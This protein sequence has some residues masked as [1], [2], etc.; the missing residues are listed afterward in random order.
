MSAPDLLN[1]LSPP[2][3]MTDAACAQVDPEL[4][5]P[6]KGDTGRVAKQVCA[7]CPVRAECLAFALARGERF[8]VWGGESAR[9]R[10]ALLAA[11]GEQPARDGG[12]RH[13]QRDVRQR[14]A[15][16]RR[17]TEAGLCDR[18]VADRIG[19]TQRTVQ[20]LRAR[21]AIPAARVPGDTRGVA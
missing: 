18:Q 13:L 8:G 19:C 11:R 9:V 20:R 10:R 16:I 4:F 12:A 14:V 5:Y 6:E 3:W 21:F 2:A 1:I 17:L 15:Q 7:A